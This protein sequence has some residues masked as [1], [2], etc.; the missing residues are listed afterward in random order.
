MEV[1][2][3]KIAKITTGWSG[4]G[5][6]EKLMKIAIHRGIREKLNLITTEIFIDLVKKSEKLIRWRYR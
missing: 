1:D 2:F 4:R 5:L 3:A 6:H